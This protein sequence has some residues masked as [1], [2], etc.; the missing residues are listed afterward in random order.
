LSLCTKVKSRW[1]KDLNKKPDTLNLLEEKVVKFLELIGT[2][3][4]FLN[5][6]PLAQALKSRIDKWDP[7]KWES[8]CK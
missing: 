6:T 4:D 2:G 1:I 3:G 7:T 5:R 8:F